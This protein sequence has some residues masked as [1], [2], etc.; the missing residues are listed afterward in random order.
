MIAHINR[1]SQLIVARRACG[2]FVDHHTSVRVVCPIIVFGVKMSE[3]AYG[4]EALAGIHQAA[5][6]RKAETYWIGFLKGVLASDA[7]ETFELDALKIEGR[8]F[9]EMLNNDDDH[10]LLTDL[11]TD[12]DDKE[13]EIFSFLKCI[14]EHRE[15][16]LGSKSGKDLF[17]EFYGMCAGIACD[18]K[19]SDLEIQHIIRFG[20]NSLVF[21]N[22][23]GISALVS[24]AKAS[25]VD[26]IVTDAESEDICH[27]ISTLV[28]DS[29]LDTGLSTY[30]NVCSVDDCI[31]DPKEVLFESRIFVLTGAF[32]SGP[33]SMIKRSIES[34]GGI[35]KAAVTDRTDYLAFASEAS[36]DWR[37]SH[38]GT[39]LIAARERRQSSD[40]PFLL[41]EHVLAKAL[42][43]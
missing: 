43:D 18:R 42:A 25:I 23:A 17:N 35:V 37:H 8:C 39:K 2:S 6:E 12:F 26:G 19:I 27:W 41:P 30:G 34:R 40:R 16:E 21:K 22:H 32:R 15:V 24:C 9:L 29:C 11:D 33:R 28:G 20:E 4:G 1:R 38:E 3:Y 10:E 7:V 13:N 31:N 36:R 14:V 5:N